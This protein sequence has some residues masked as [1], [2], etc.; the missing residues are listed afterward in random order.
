MFENTRLKGKLIT[1]FTERT[2]LTAVSI[3]GGLINSCA[4]YDPSGTKA[5]VVKTCSIPNDQ[6]GTIIGHW[7]SAPIPIAV[8]QGDFNTDEIKAILAAANTWNTFFQSA[9]GSLIFTTNNN[10]DNSSIQVMA[11]PNSNNAS[12]TFCSQLAYTGNR[13]LTSIG[14]YKS[15]TWPAAYPATAIGLTTNC[16]YPSTPYKSIRMAIIELNYQSFF[17]QGTKVPDLQSIVTHELGH[18]TG[19]DHSCEF[20]T[21]SGT[22]ICSDASINPDY[23][24]AIMF[25]QFG[26]DSVT[27]LGEQRR[28]LNTNDEERENCLYANSSSAITN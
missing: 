25:P 18:L 3:A 16:P 15:G 23:T 13:F 10:G 26:F 12:Q 28:S 5:T 14:I 22:P 27:G 4:L 17:V 7:P 19:L 1:A 21:K 6:S 9:Q 11:I 24:N 20:S 8:H 2:L